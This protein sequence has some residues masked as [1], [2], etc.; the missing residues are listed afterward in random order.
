MK[1]FRLLMKCLCSMQTFGGNLLV[2]FHWSIFFYFAG[3]LNLCLLK[4]I[5]KASYLSLPRGVFFSSLE[6]HLKDVFIPSFPRRLFFAIRK[7]SLRCLFLAFPK[8]FIFRLSKDVLKTS[9]SHPTAESLKN[10]QKK[11]S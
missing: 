7:T 3:D 2:R 9:D 1:Y 11:T 10:D 5:L 4:D 8:A 6:R